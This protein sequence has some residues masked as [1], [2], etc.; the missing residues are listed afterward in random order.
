MEITQYRPDALLSPA[1]ARRDAVKTWPV[2]GPGADALTK[3]PP[4]AD[5]QP[6]DGLFDTFLDAVN[7][8]QHLPGASTVYRQQT[9]DDINAF[10]RMA[11][12]FLFG[13]P[14]GLAAGA[15]N[16]F[17]H[18]L[19][20]QDLGGHM[21]ALFEGGPDQPA[22]GHVE[23]AEA[24]DAEPL[25]QRPTS[26]GLKQYQ[27]YATAQSSYRKGYGADASDV[28]WSSNVWTQHAI[29]QAAAQY[30]NQQELSAGPGMATPRTLIAGV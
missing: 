26:V 18:F 1:N 27:A 16:S 4:E 12:G 2:S 6:A 19:T 22:T 5:A 3:P 11:G 13:G 29:Q 14:I 8:L 9:G 30:Q 20:G 15:A 25:F 10:S 17:L 23:T 24:R 28:A 7:P 21:M